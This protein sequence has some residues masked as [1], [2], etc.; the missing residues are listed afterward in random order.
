MIDFLP[1]DEIKA[2]ESFLEW[3]KKGIDNILED[4]GRFEPENKYFDNVSEVYEYYSRLIPREL[5]FEF[6][7]YLAKVIDYYT[8]LPAPLQG[9][10][11]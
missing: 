7:L 3:R 4:G 9:F 5:W 11:L 1:L 6:S 8:E 10:V 2:P